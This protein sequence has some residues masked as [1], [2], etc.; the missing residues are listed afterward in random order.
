MGA[1]FRKEWVTVA[2]GIVPDGDSVVLPVLSGSMGPA[3]V[4]GGTVSI[5][6]VPSGGSRAG[7]I[8]VF[9]DKQGLVAHRQL[10]RLRFAGRSTIYQKG[11]AN[12]LGS[13]ICADRIVGVISEARDPGGKVLYSREL[14][15]PEAAR[16]GRRQLV[17]LLRHPLQRA[18]RSAKRFLSKRLWDGRPQS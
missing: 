5:T 11:D 7:D 6:R 9:R 14:H 4:Q 10:L 12:P 13:W 15:Q 1:P 18:A 16:E 17:R 2:S 8:I 3:I